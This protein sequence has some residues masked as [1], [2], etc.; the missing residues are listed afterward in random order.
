MYMMWDVRAAVYRGDVLC[1]GVLYGTISCS[2]VQSIQQIVELQFVILIYALCY[3]CTYRTERTSLKSIFGSS[4][5]NSG[6]NKRWNMALTRTTASGSLSLTSLGT[7]VFV[8]PSMSPPVDGPV[9]AVARSDRGVMG[10]GSACLR[11]H[12]FLAAS[13]SLSSMKGRTLD[14]ILQNIRKFKISAF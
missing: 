7:S 10:L 13:L 6:K 3:F 9:P 14:R 1:Y 4:M 8:S 12:R 11:Q 5:V 2:T